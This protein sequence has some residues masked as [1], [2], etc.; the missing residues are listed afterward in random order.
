SKK[1]NPGGDKRITLQPGSKVYSAVN[2]FDH[3]SKNQTAQGLAIA[4]RG[5]DG[6]QS[7]YYSVVMKGQN[8]QFTWTEADVLNWN[9]KKPYDF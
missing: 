2:L 7:P 5:T 8:Q 9:T 3:G 1:D 6:H 4:L